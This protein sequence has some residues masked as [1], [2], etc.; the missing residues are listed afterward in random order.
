ML[1]SNL[2]AATALLAT[3]VAAHGAVTSY[4]IDGVTY[5]GYVPFHTPHLAACEVL[6]VL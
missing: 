2:F 1:F 3:Q 4:V 6:T 5:P